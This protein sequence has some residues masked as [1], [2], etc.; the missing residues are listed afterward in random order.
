MFYN[1]QACFPLR[2]RKYNPCEVVFLWKWGIGDN[3]SCQASSYPF[4]TKKQ[5][6]GRISSCNG[7]FEYVVGVTTDLGWLKFACIFVDEGFTHFPAI[8]EDFLDA[9]VDPFSK[10]A[11]YCSVNWMNSGSIGIFFRT[12]FCKFSSFFFFFFQLQLG[13]QK[14]QY[15]WWIKSNLKVAVISNLRLSF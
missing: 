1:Q 11:L 10:N 3:P 7:S 6:N 15:S 2:K 14:W 5:K 12:T 4:V 8:V 13:M 9:Y